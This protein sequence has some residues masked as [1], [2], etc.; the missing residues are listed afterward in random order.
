MWSLTQTWN[1]GSCIYTL[2][3]HFGSANH[4]I[5]AFDGCLYLHGLTYSPFDLFLFLSVEEGWDFYAEAGNPLIRSVPLCLGLSPVI[6][7]KKTYLISKASWRGRPLLCLHRGV[8][9]ISTKRVS[10]TD[11]TLY[12]LSLL[13]KGVQWKSW[14]ERR[15]R[16]SRAPGTSGEWLGD[17]WP[18]VRSY[19]KRP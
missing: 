1:N 11:S 15:K 6:L 18:F 16:R 12:L 2:R 7:L 9:K 3:K 8:A 17:S 4:H 13:Q 14:R 10:F 19:H 5:D